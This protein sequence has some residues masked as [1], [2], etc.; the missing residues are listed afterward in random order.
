M[1]TQPVGGPAKSRMPRNP[2]A[3]EEPN[4]PLDAWWVA[5]T[6]DEVTTQ[7]CQRWILGLPVVLYRTDDGTAVALDDRCPHRWAP[8]SLGKV[9]GS[10]I[11]CPYHGFQFGRDGR[12]TRVPTQAAVPSVARVRSYPVLERGPF[13]WIWT[14]QPGREAEAEVPP[15]LDWTIDPTRVTASGRM[16]VACNY[17]ALKENVLDLS[18]F[19]YVHEATLAVTDWVAPPR[20]E[21]TPESVSYHQEF[22]LMPLPAH[23]GVPSEIGCEHPVNRHAWGSYVSPALQL[24]GVDIND[25]AGHV[26]GRQ[27]FTLRIL[28]ATT[29]IDEGRCSYWWFFSQDYG[30]G[31]DAAARLT[32]RIEAAF[33]EDKAIL[34]ATEA[35]VRRDPRGRDTID[36][37]VTCDHAGIEARRRVQRLADA[38]FIPGGSAGGELQASAG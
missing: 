17:M 15:A 2:V 18:H 1:A 38:A 22:T 10:D 8:L 4:Y 37:S 12:C 26:G 13:L 21:K 27:D 23:Y 32:E 7:P 3:L 31:S 14:G 11:V 30:H 20:V 5:A 28:H 19:A 16:E 24:A 6:G 35:M 33:L 29:P 9:V 36:V 34:E 25:P